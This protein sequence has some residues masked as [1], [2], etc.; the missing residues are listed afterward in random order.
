[1]IPSRFPRWLVF[2]ILIQTISLSPLS[3]QDTLGSLVPDTPITRLDGSSIAVQDLTLGTEIWTWM[4][5]EKP[6]QGKV[7]GIRRVHSDTYLELKAGDH[8]LEATGSHRIALAGG[9]LVRLDTV[10][11]GDKIAVWGTK[12]I[13]E[14]TVLSLRTL[15][16]TLITYDL[17]IEGH[18]FFLIDGI[19]VGD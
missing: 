16:V 13:Q 19:L 18:R 7:T 5:G 6:A 3:A 4:P 1:M 12:G 2:G 9:K 15:P 11:E 14:A 17:T 8:V 10:K